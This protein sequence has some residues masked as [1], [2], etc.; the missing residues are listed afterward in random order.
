M[1]LIEPEEKSEISSFD[2]RWFMRVKEGKKNRDF[3]LFIEYKL[4]FE[5]RCIRFEVY[6]ITISI[7]LAPS[8]YVSHVILSCFKLNVK[9]SHALHFCKP[10]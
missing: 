3:S 1:W 4:F 6:G 9:T 10:H 8:L 2:V 7:Y 5:P